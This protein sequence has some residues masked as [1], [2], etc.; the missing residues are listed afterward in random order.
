MQKINLAEVFFTK[1]ETAVAKHTGWFNSKF[2]VNSIT[3]VNYRQFC[4]QNTA[5]TPIP[6]KN[7][8]MI[9]LL[10]LYTHLLI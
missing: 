6:Q 7:D 5:S 1:D 9:L 2:S 10:L 3:M 4:K 8:I